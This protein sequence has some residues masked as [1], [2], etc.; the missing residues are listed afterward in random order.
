MC[1]E[2]LN[3]LVVNAALT[4]LYG[5]PAL[6]IARPWRMA[7]EVRVSG[8]IR[9][10]FVVVSLQAVSGLIWNDVVHAY[11][12]VQILLA[13]VLWVVA[14]WLWRRWDA[15]SVSGTR[16]AGGTGVGGR[17]GCILVVVLLIALTVRLLHPLRAA[18]LGQSDAYVHLLFFKDIVTNGVIRHPAYP[19]GYHWVMALPSILF[20]LDPYLMARYGGAWFGLLLCASTYAFLRAWVSA[21]PAL[22]GAFLVACCPLFSILIKTGVGAFANQMGLALVPM[23][24]LAYGR[25]RSTTGAAA[26][27]TGMELVVMALGLAATVPLMLFR[28][29]LV[30]GM[31]AIVSAVWR[32]RRASVWARLLGLAL[33]L[34]P[35]GAMTAAHFGRSGEFW[36]RVTGEA[37]TGARLREETL[38]HD[39]EQALQ[40]GGKPPSVWWTAGRDVVR[41]KRWGMSSVPMNAAAGAWLAVFAVTL[42]SGTRRGVV[43]ESL[44]G[45][46]GLL[47][48]VQTL[49]GWLE[50][51]NYQRGGWPFM[52][53]TAMVAGRIGADVYGRIR[54]R[55]VARG[56]MIVGVAG[57]IVWIG[58]CPPRH[59]AVTSSAEQELVEVTRQLADHEAH[60]AGVRAAWAFGAG[61]DAGIR[62]WLAPDRPTTLVVRSTSGAGTQGFWELPDAVSVLGS[63]L[64]IVNVRDGNNL[65]G[66][67]N[68]EEQTIFFLD[69]AKRLPGQKVGAMASLDAA[70]ADRYSHWQ[71]SHYRVNAVIREFLERL[72]SEDWSVRSVRLSENAE[73]V[74]C[75]SRRVP[76]R[77]GEPGAVPA[78]GS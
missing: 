34:A 73:V 67:P 37:L 28:L 10:L 45:W 27:R 35:A 64:R 36:T 68:D 69:R 46:L 43:F 20:R 32:E 18:Y 60:R 74:I 62:A 54:P 51:S 19:P 77:Q 16:S 58:F 59:V 72:P 49:T 38:R 76:T 52:L 6:C 70:Q 7:A 8:L 78:D 31:D 63:P 26:R 48:G 55:V 33:L 4:V 30:M 57:C 1:A 47:T 42:V 15:G 12:H 40:A 29:G 17:E 44:V 65:T 61:R 50:F 21:L 41:V 9:A 3:T 56:L 11:P 23:V 2:I 14:G 53:A 39:P 22:L 24:L 71:Y 75:S 25:W 13:L 66:V 5:V